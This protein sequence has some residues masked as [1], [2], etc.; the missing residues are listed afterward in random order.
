MN[1]LIRSFKNDEFST[2]ANWWTLQNE[3]PP[4]EGMMVEDGTFVLELNNIPILSATVFL[5]QSKE[6]AYF[7]GFIKNP[8]VKKFNLETY[9]KMLWQHCCEWAS[10]RGYKRLIVYCNVNKIVEKYTR[11]GMRKTASDLTSLV[12]EI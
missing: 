6:M 1:C 12:R 5:T 10:A 7:E 8:T 3:C 4:L 9:G 11:F 2:I